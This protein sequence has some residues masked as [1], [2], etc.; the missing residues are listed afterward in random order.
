MLETP[1]LCHGGKEKNQDT[2][3]PE[4]YPMT[5][6]EKGIKGQT[7]SC[8]GFGLRASAVP[9][10]RSRRGEPQKS[11]QTGPC[12][13]VLCAGW[14]TRLRKA[15]RATERKLPTFRLLET[16]EIFFSSGKEQQLHCPDQKM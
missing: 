13:C 16:D 12:S 9:R 4:G 7:L 5:L 1:L 10:R 6:T 2:E 3:K 8:D 14:T 15:G 11:L